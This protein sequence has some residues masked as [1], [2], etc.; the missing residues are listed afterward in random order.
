MSFQERTLP[1]A[2]FAESQ[3]MRRPI[4]VPGL[5]SPRGH[6]DEFRRAFQVGF[7]KI[8]ESV[9]IAAIAASAL[10]F[11]T[12]IHRSTRGRQMA[13]CRTY[14]IGRSPLITASYTT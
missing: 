10:A 9:L 5:E 3:R 1:V 14:S 7:R 12:E 13:V 4:D 6:A 2:R 8:H 11:K